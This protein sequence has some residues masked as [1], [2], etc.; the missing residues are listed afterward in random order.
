MNFR[1]RLVPTLTTAGCLVVLVGL[2]S[3]Q[4]RRNGET[5]AKIAAFEEKLS[6]SPLTDADLSRS[7]AA[8]WNRRARLEGTFR[9]SPRFLVGRADG[10]RAGYAIVEVMDLTDGV[11]LLVDRGWVAHSRLQEGLDALPRTET[12]TGVLLPLEGPES[13]PM[14]AQDG[15]AERWPTRSH[16][17]MARTMTEP[18][19]PALMRVGSELHPSER[20]DPS[21]LLVQRWWIRP[22]TRPHL[23]YAATWF[24]IALVLVWI[25]ILASRDSTSA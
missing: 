4:L 22:D 24:A 23:E 17:A 1:P 25:W 6:A 5:N 3:W 16:A 18:L 19:L 14:A 13:R 10:S 2:G 7:P 20:S 8:L 15:I 11:A 12:V 21:Q 9:D